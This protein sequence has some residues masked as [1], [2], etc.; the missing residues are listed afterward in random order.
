MRVA[1]TLNKERN[2]DISEVCKAFGIKLEEYRST[3]DI[4]K[5]NNDEEGAFRQQIWTVL[6]NV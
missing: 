1:N 5:L 3:S 6:Y 4:R 2:N